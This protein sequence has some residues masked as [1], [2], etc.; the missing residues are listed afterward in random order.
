M[1]ELA[2]VAR[3]QPEMANDFPGRVPRYIQRGRGCRAVL[4]NGEVS[5]ENDELTRVRSGRIC[6]SGR[7]PGAIG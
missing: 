5:L 7:S 3:L 6:A 4:V 2:N 1:F